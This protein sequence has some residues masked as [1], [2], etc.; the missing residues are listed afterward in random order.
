MPPTHNAI[1]YQHKGAPHS[2][3]LVILFNTRCWLSAEPSALLEVVTSPARTHT[4]TNQ[5]SDTCPITFHSLMYRILRHTCR[6][7]EVRNPL[8]GTIGWLRQLQHLSQTASDREMVSCALECTGLAL[9]FL[10]NLT[11]LFKL[12]A[13]QLTP[14]L[15]PTRLKDVIDQVAMV[16]RP[17]LEDGVQLVT[18]YTGV[19]HLPEVNC[20][21]KLLLHVLLNLCQNAAR[22]TTQGSVSISC[23]VQPHHRQM[24]GRESPGS[25]LRVKFEICDTG[26]GI[27]SS[28]K[29]V[30]FSR[31]KSVGGV[32][33]GLYLS[34]ELVR[35]FGSSL[36]VTS[37]RNR[38]A[39][40]GTSFHFELNLDL[41]D[42]TPN[43][44]DYR[45]ACNHGELAA[46]SHRDE[47]VDM[48]DTP[49]AATS[50]VVVAP[51]V[52][53]S[54]RSAVS[55]QVVDREETTSLPSITVTAQLKLEK[56]LPAMAGA[57]AAG[58]LVS[59]DAG[60]H[61]GITSAGD[62][63]EKSAAAPEGPAENM[64]PRD[65]CALVADD[66]LVNRKILD[67]I[68]TQFGWQVFQ[69]QTAEEVSRGCALC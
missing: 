4:V 38:E 15:G 52:A 69:A 3:G 43:L 10:E 51:M 61:K 2:L 36:I 18:D 53:P 57:G 26:Q 37:P 14:R 68:F 23:N 47:T 65:I 28:I 56:G 13:K 44:A 31:Y 59:E 24:S 49:A 1:T 25:T 5:C 30:L 29:D 16:V 12:E 21:A 19:A 66:H 32:G 9:K 63:L 50:M 7:H 39:T 46:V 8:N 45:G 58:L 27:S 17:Q 33:I 60:E 42:S 64:L 55:V 62:S 20:D 11:L 35:A 6:S 41:S 34:H 48:E 22:F 54:T 67:M 40:S